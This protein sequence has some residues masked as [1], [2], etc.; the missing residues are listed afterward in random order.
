MQQ[1]WAGS[2][3]IKA[4]IGGG[5]IRSHQGLERQ[6]RE[7]SNALRDPGA[8]RNGAGQQDRCL[9]AVREIKITGSQAADL[10]GKGGCRGETNDDN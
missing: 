6:V 10:P 9:H 5:H 1:P 3:S 4:G 2:Y 8:A 7:L